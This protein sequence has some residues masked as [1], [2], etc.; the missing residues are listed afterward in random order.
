MAR[1][2]ER[3]LPAPGLGGPWKGKAFVW[4][5]R[6]AESTGR[7]RWRPG[8]RLTHKSRSASGELRKSRSL[9]Q[10][11]SC[12]LFPSWALSCVPTHLGVSVTSPSSTTQPGDIAEC[13]SCPDTVHEV[14]GTCG[15]GLTV[16][17]PGG[18][19]VCPPGHLRWCPWVGSKGPQRDTAPW[20]VVCMG[21]CHSHTPNCR[22]TPLHR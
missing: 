15:C 19:R 6:G 9:P 7:A 13:V 22:K 10:A 3:A 12:D 21:P 17:S 18:G 14:L 8:F 5:K 16:F 20:C 11:A 4:G 1:G 2:R